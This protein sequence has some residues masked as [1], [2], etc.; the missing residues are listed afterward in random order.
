MTG[1]LQVG[2]IQPSTSP[3]SNSVLLVRKIDGSWRF[4]VDYRELNKA[5]VADKFPIPVIEELLDEL[6]GAKIFSKIDL[7]TG[8]HQIRVASEDIPKTAFR[9]HDRHNEFLVMPFSLINAPATFQFLMIDIFR[10][11]LR[12]FVLVFFDDILIYST[13]ET[14]HLFHL[15]AVFQIL[16]EHQ[17]FANAKKCI[18]AQSKI[19]YLGHIINEDGVSTDPSKVQAMLDWPLPKTLKALRGFL[20]L[21]GY[22]RRFIANYGQIAWP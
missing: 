7:K 16:R 20:S 4:S 10:D 13:H 3:Y 1:M 21:I 15:Q 22:Y 2:I 5:T 17:L 12:H 8:Y 11:H 18:F 6:H 9:M 14:T 19:D